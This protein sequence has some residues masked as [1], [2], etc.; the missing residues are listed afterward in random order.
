MPDSKLIEQLNELWQK[1]L[2]YN[3]FEK[4]MLEAVGKAY[5][6][7]PWRLHRQVSFNRILTGDFQVVHRERYND[8]VIE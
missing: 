1:H 5:K 4:A 2:S 3:D 8:V 6:V 7:E